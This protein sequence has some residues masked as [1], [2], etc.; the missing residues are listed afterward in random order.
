MGRPNI[1]KTRWPQPLFSLLLFHL[2]KCTLDRLSDFVWF[3]RCRFACMCFYCVLCDYVHCSL[4]TVL[5]TVC[6]PALA[7]WSRWCQFRRGSEVSAS[8]V[9]VKSWRQIG[10]TKRSSCCSLL[11]STTPTA[12]LFLSFK[13]VPGS[14]SF[15]FSYRGEGQPGRGRW[16]NR[17]SEA[18]RAGTQPIRSSTKPHK[19]LALLP[20]PILSSS[21]LKLIR[22]PPSLHFQI[23]PSIKPATTLATSPFFLSVLLLLC[24]SLSLFSLSLQ[25]KAVWQQNVKLSC[26]MR[27]WAFFLQVVMTRATIRSF[28]PPL[29]S[30]QPFIAFFLIPLNLSFPW[31]NS[32]SHFI[33][34]PPLYH[35]PI[36]PLFFSLQLVCVLSCPFRCWF[37]VVV[38]RLVF[39][40][41]SSSPFASLSPHLSNYVWRQRRLILPPPTRS[42]QAGCRRELIS[43]LLHALIKKGWGWGEGEKNK[44]G[45]IHWASHHRKGGLCVCWQLQTC[46]MFVAYAYKYVRTLLSQVCVFIF[47]AV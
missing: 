18:G 26:G 10:Q 36:P 3:H 32:P 28:F 13:L 6:S 16:G 25:N 19:L 5:Y 4:F 40:S 1:L 38:D 34:F 11:P 2:C 7:F 42:C 47:L 33:F 29:S 46:V 30:S 39:I 31:S 43:H 41:S 37:L 22:L 35:L 44:E 8:K 17:P 21:I 23:V 9:K 15:S 24:G 12:Q 27:G 20:R 45:Y 14:S